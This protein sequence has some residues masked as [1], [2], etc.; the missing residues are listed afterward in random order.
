MK[1]KN[2]PWLSFLWSFSSSVHRALLIFPCACPGSRFYKRDQHPGCSVSSQRW[3][4]LRI[5]PKLLWVSTPILV[6]L[7]QTSWGE[8]YGRKSMWQSARDWSVRKGHDRHVHLYMVVVLPSSGKSIPQFKRDV[9]GPACIAKTLTPTIG[10][11]CLL[12]FSCFLDWYFPWFDPHY[13]YASG[14]CKEL[15]WVLLLP[16]EELMEGRV[17]KIRWLKYCSHLRDVELINLPSSRKECSHRPY[18]RFCD[19]PE[20]LDPMRAIEVPGAAGWEGSPVLLATLRL[21]W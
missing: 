21:W 20:S 7:L 12:A 14:G 15:S 6:S 4:N 19:E 1:R 16:P 3:Q 11:S 2:L 8:I 17:L 9:V 13:L 18:V 5:S 10:N